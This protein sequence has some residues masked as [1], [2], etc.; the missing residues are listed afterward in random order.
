MKETWRGDDEAESRATTV[1][2]TAQYSR[3]FMVVAP[4]TYIYNGGRKQ[5]VNNRSWLY[6]RLFQ[7]YYWMNNRVFGSKKVRSGLQLTKRHWLKNIAVVV[8]FHDSQVRNARR[9]DHVF[10]ANENSLTTTQ[11]NDQPVALT[12]NFGESNH[13][14]TQMHQIL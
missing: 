10:S 13:D 14:L 6:S 11:I 3:A 8:F 12:T 4:S 9:A 2:A 7:F 1:V 5:R